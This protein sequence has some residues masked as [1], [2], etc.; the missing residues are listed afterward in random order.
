MNKEVHEYIEKQKSPQKEILIKLRKLILK[1]VP[2]CKEEMMWGVPVFD[3]GKFY[4][5]SLRNQV[6]F[7]FAISGLDKK[8]VDLFE[9]SGKMMRHIKVF[10]LEDVDEKRFGK[11]I[12]M[13]HR[14]AVCKPC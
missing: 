9:G 2:N 1:T 12:K 6:N 4:T 14:K 7:G 5:A 8:E 3:G 13:V 11:L 10:S